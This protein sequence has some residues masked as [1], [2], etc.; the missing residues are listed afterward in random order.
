MIKPI[1]K[2]KPLYLPHYILLCKSIQ[3]IHRDYSLP[4]FIYKVGMS[5]A[6]DTPELSLLV[7]YPT[8]YVGVWV[9]YIEVYWLC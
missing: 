2:Q 6:V 9:R 5:S 3:P 8:L 1:F 7:Y 4:T